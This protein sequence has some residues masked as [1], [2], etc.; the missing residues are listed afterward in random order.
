MSATEPEKKSP[1]SPSASTSEDLNAEA[2]VTETTE[3]A[4]ARRRRVDT[5]W[6]RQRRD[7]YVRLLQFFERCESKSRSDANVDM[8]Q[9]VNYLYASFRKADRLLDQTYC[10]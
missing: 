8:S 3:A 6:Q 9:V 5:M 7:P 1:P 2:R 4:L 10:G